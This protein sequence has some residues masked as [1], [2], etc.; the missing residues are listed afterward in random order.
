[1]EPVNSPHIY[2]AFGEAIGKIKRER[3]YNQFIDYN[4]NSNLN[5]KRF[6]RETETKSNNTIVDTKV[7]NNRKYLLIKI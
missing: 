1:M 5:V 7:T 4:Y 3:Y 2:N 6:L